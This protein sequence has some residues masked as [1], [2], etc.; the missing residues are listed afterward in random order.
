VSYIVI[1]DIPNTDIKEGM[2]LEGDGFNVDIMVTYRGVY[3]CDINSKVFREYVE[4][5]NNEGVEI[6]NGK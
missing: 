2:I 1:K 5:V 3:V 4:E 6:I